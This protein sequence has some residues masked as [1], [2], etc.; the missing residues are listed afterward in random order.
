MQF[1]FFRNVKQ[2]FINSLG[3]NMVIVWEYVQVES[4]SHATCVCVCGAALY[5]VDV[6]VIDR[7]TADES[8]RPRRQQ[9]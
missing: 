4:R 5:A 1:F 7:T 3:P 2:I 9:L 6:R 8:D